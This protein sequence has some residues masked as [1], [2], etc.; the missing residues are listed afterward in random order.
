MV[1]GYLVIKAY[2]YYNGRLVDECWLCKRSIWDDW[3][4]GSY[5]ITDEDIKNIVNILLRLFQEV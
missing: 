1:I 4:G 5:I 2:F 3:I